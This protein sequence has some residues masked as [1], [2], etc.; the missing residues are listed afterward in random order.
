M[1][2]PEATSAST[3]ETREAF[4]ATPPSP[5]RRRLL[6]RIAAGAG[7]ITALLAGI[8]FIGFLF[9]PAARRTPPVWRAVG[10]VDEFAIGETVKVIYVDPEPL[11][12]A[13]FAGRNAAWLRRSG[14]RE[15]IAFSTYC[16]HTGCPVRWTEGAQMFMC[17]CH[18]GTF[19]SDGSVAAGPPPRPLD[20]LSVRV[21]N[22]QVE[23][24]PIGVPIAT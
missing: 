2:E 20:R 22:G 15:F 18:G 9:A 19:H 21:Q 12:W 14:E 6:A 16:T 13:G 4:T 3:H 10:S 17:P 5:A 1:T 24:Q 11:P 7:G 8:P 23:I